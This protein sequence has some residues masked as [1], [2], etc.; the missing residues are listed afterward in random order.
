M[1][2][3]PN[4]RYLFGRRE[5]ERWDPARPGYQPVEH[6][7]GV[8]ED[9][10][11]PIV[12]AVNQKGQGVV[13]IEAFTSGSL[14]ES[15]SGQADLVL[16]GTADIAFV[17]P[18]LTPARFPEHAVIQLPGLFQSAREATLTYNAMIRVG[19][20]HDL[21]GFIVIGAVANYPLV[22]H[23]RAPMTSLADLKDKKTAGIFAGI[24]IPLGKA[25]SA[26]TGVS[27][28]RQGATAVTDASKS[29]QPEV[30][31]YGWRIQDSEGATTY[32]SVAGSSWK[33][34]SPP[35]AAASRSAGKRSILR[36]SVL[37]N[38]STN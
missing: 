9:S 6:N 14:G 17:N 15:F 8:Y 23:T 18:G 34:Y 22:L 31:S 13:R 36:S 11:K 24:S 32:R 7:E 35:G 21:E 3:F 37:G 2:T 30:G 16:N 12:D 25:T 33:R 29:I 10:I 5:Y 38:T 19:A 20:F 4:A 1:P 26:S 28:T 27:M